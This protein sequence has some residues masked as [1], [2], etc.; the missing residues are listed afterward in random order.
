MVYSVGRHDLTLKLQYLFV[1]W[2]KP[3]DGF[4]VEMATASIFTLWQ[5]FFVNIMSAVLLLSP[6]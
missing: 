5:A 3:F 2:R 6:L 4:C 1:G